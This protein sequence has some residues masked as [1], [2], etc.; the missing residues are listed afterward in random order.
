MIQRYINIIILLLILSIN[1]FSQTHKYY[2]SSISGDDTRSSVMAQNPNTPWASISKLNQFATSL[3]AGDSV[4]FKCGET[5]YGK[6]VIGKSGT[7]AQPIVFDSYGV[8]AKPIITGFSSVT[9]WT[10]V[11]G[12]IWESNSAVKSSTTMLNMVTGSNIFLPIGRS[13]KVGATNQGYLNIDSHVGNT[14]I[15]SSGLSGYPSYAGGQ[16]VTKRQHWIIDVDNITSN[17]GTTVNFTNSDAYNINNGWGFF[18]QNN[19][20]ACTA[21]NDWYYNTT[22]RKVGMYST[23]NPSG[24]DIRVATIDTLVTIN[25]KSYI[26]FK[27][28]TF[29]GAN[30]STIFITFS[31]N[32][33][34]DNCTIKMAGRDG[35]TMTDAGAYP[36]NDNNI[37]VSNTYFSYINNNAI[38]CHAT[39][40]VTV[41][42]C[43]FKNI[44]AVAGMGGNSDGQGFGIQYAGD[45]STITNNRFD[46]CGYTVIYFRGENITVSNNYITNFCFIKDDGA[47]IYTYAT[48]NTG[49]IVSANIVLNGI[50]SPY[51]TDNGQRYA[52]GIYMDDE[53][54]NVT[55]QGN[56]VSNCDRG[57]YIHNAHE[58]TIRSNV[59]Y[60]NY[61]H[62]LDFSHDNIAPSDP[63]RNI[64]MKKNI[65]FSKNSGESVWYYS[66]NASDVMS[67]GTADS[68]YYAR[69]IAENSSVFTLDG[70]NYSLATWQAASSQDAHSKKSPKTVTDTSQILFYYNA[71]NAATTTSLGASYIDVY[72]NPYIG[73]ITLQ[74]FTS[75]VLIFQSNV[76]PLTVN[77]VNNA[78]NCNGDST[79]LTLTGVGGVPPYTYSLD[80]STWKVSNIFRVIAGSYTV[81]AKD[82]ASTIAN[83]SYNVTQPT[84]ITVTVD[85]GLAPT[86]VTSHASGGSGYFTYKLDAGSYQSSNI[87]TNVAAGNHTITAKDSNNCTGTLNFSVISGGTPLT[88][89]NIVQDSTAL[90]YGGTT[91]ATVTATGGTAPYTYLWSNS[92]TTQTATDLTAATY[93][94]TVTDAASHVADTSITITQ[95]TIVSIIQITADSLITT[96]GGTTQLHY[97]ATG[98]TG[99]LQYKLDGGS[100]SSADSTGGVSAGN[101]TLYVKDAKGC[102]VSQFFTITQ[103]PPAVPASINTFRTKRR[104]YFNG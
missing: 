6:I 72:S 18:F 32:I 59:V 101:H 51:G 44:A 63:I 64:T 87:F 65:F 92:Q 49:T 22:T 60:G 43:N 54:T 10:N 39:P 83:N 55:I 37:T 7:A 53:T 4:L 89:S 11:S 16:I 20:N 71:T 81:Y 69:P 46:S 31:Q 77:A 104:R 14:Q 35:I 13:P 27:N 100:Y 34:I 50:G 48:D 103:P 24:L 98:G 86:T 30:M 96:N 1:G 19:S 47:G 56:T 3:V 70:T 68:N 79:N 45:N 84:T 73:S 12:N 94:V 62:Q 9:S 88:I 85:Y 91:S 21:Q 99:S 93:T 80:G 17:S 95:P 33:V 41:T 29:S 61:S 2:F 66:T 38:D 8:G 15:T 23:S 26:T 40:F 75:S 90:C 97:S 25:S 52:E 57:I 67:F 82:A 28:I 36:G 5:F 42:N 58:I 78:I 74:P 76:V 102:V